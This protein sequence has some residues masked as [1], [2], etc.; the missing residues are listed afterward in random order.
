MLRLLFLGCILFLMGIP[1]VQ[2]EQAV[3][4]YWKWE[5]PKTAFEK[6]SIDF[7]EVMSG[8]PPKD[9]IPPIDTPVFQSIEEQKAIL[10]P[11]EPVISLSIEGNARAY[12]LRVLMWHEI[13]NDV[14]G[15][16]PVAV[17]F[18]PLCNA[19]IAFDARVN[20]EPTTFGTTGKLRNSD[21]IMYD[22]A[23]ESWWQ[24]FSGTAIIGE[25]TGT[26]LKVLPSR[27]E[28][29]ERFAQRLPHG[30]V[31]VPNNESSRAYGKNPYLNYDSSQ[32]PFL[33]RGTM[34]E[35][36]PAFARVV[37]IGDIPLRQMLV[38]RAGA[39]L[40]RTLPGWEA[41]LDDADRRARGKLL[42][43]LQAYADADMNV[44][45]AARALSVHPNTIY[46]RM[47]RITDVAGVSPLGY[48]GLTEILLA[49]ECR[50]GDEV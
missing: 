39:S 5:W 19:A 27:L 15:T 3:P 50:R 47:Q 44:L 34:P 1:I 25:Q 42:A 31:L 22:R 11:T 4:S 9:G 36:S 40:R 37:A 30:K 14:I 17:T 26:R 21:L 43:T 48:H 10:A 6:T 20:G 18:C 35:G 7:K 23:T 32:F 16:L 24:Q 38:S 29:F 8:G 33:Y 49:I 41:A 12:P 13:V 28:S 46:A 2:A 45:K